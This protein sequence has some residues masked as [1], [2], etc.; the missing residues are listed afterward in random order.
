[1]SIKKTCI[2]P[3]KQMEEDATRKIIRGQE[4]THPTINI[5]IRGEEIQTVEEFCYLGCLFTRDFSSGREI[6]VRL[7]KASTAFN[8]LRHAV[9]YRRT[10]SMTARLRIFRACVLPVLLYG[11]K[12]WTLTTALEQRLCTF[13]HRCLR[14]I[15]GVNMGDRMA[16]RQLLE[17]TGQPALIDIMRRN[18]LRWFGH[19]NRMIRDDGSVPMVKK[20]MFSY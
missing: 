15:I 7:T 10:V 9:W 4:T 8:M 12:T 2:M 17:L 19:A 20:A 1:M 3:M 5:N 16:N 6:D 13:Y 18:R 14:T 11:S